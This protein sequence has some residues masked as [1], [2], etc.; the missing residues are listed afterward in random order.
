MLF[1]VLF[2]MHCVSNQHKNVSQLLQKWHHVRNHLRPCEGHVRHHVWHHVACTLRM[3]I[4]GQ[5][6]DPCHQSQKP[7]LLS[8]QKTAWPRVRITTLMCMHLE[9]LPHMQIDTHTTRCEDDMSH[10]QKMAKDDR[11][12]PTILGR[13]LV[14]WVVASSSLASRDGSAAVSPGLKSTPTRAAAPSAAG[15]ACRWSRAASSSPCPACLSSNCFSQTSM[16]KH[17]Q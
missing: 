6:V 2:T 12:P 5:S 9:N 1:G 13:L 3:H 8:L 11:Y 4:T 16:H 10:Q 7:T 15:A 17:C 14:S